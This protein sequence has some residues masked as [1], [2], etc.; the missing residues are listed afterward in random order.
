M[1][2]QI[3]ENLNVSPDE[4]DIIDELTSIIAGWG[5]S[6]EKQDIFGL[7]KNYTN[8][9]SL[10]EDVTA[11]GE[12]DWEKYREN[13][14]KGSANN[15][16]N[17]V[18]F[19]DKTFYSIVEMLVNEKELVDWEMLDSSRVNGTSESRLN[20][21]NPIAK[22]FGKK[23]SQEDGDVDGMVNKL[24][25]AVTDNYEDI[26]SGEID[27]F[28]YLSLRELKTYALDLSEVV[29]QRQTMSWRVIVEGYDKS[30]V[31]D[32]VRNNNEGAYDPWEYDYDL[33]NDEVT[34]RDGIEIN[35]IYEE[36]TIKEISKINIIDNDLL[37]EEINRINKLI[38]P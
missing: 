7:I 21:I 15:Y 28:K 36:E 13:G 19:T 5:E 17:I 32:I 33:E 10:Y 34:Y 1:I 20:A 30:E 24:Y 35:S 9:K 2:K 16:R 8:N 12:I 3:T 27:E 23:L 38:K 11:K 37:K 25:W 29:E 4:N 6:H 26:K 18:T 31:R 14:Y 22:V